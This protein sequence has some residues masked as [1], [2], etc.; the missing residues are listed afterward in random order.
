MNK[1]VLAL[2]LGGTNARFA[3]VRSDGEILA[4]IRVPTIKNGTAEQILDLLVKNFG[5]I[6]AGVGAVA[7]AAAIPALI[8][9]DSG[10][11]QKLPNLPALEGIDLAEVL[12]ERT[13]LDTFIENDATAATIGEH[14][15]GA[16]KGFDNVVGITLG[17]GIGG[18]L[19]FNGKPFRGNGGSAGEIGH[20]CVEP[21]GVSC[22]CGSHGCVEQYA[23]GT[24]IAR[25]AREAGLVA[26]TSVDVF[27]LG[28]SGDKKALDV[29]TSMGAYLGIAIAGLVNV[30]N[31]D[32]IVVCGGVTAGWELFTD[33]V[34]DEVKKRAYRDPAERAK[35]IRGS[36]GDDAGILGVAKVAFDIMS[37]N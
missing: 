11:L 10:V 27:D 8:N 32:M 3:A 37:K 26:A 21:N 20:V 15:L 29:F 31:P 34:R 24:A 6:S 5:E 30:L 9:T 17:T 14:W 36:L 13:G 2:D 12:K 23:S 35:I 25:M 33:S 7:I 18:G 16:C 28:K 22:G 4:R 19:I 1:V